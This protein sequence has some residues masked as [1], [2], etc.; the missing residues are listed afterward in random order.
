MRHDRFTGP[1]WTTRCVLKVCRSPTLVDDG[2]SGVI[3]TLA[4]ERIANE[5]VME[6]GASDV[7]A[8]L[9]RR[10][11][12]IT[13]LKDAI[14]DVERAHQT[15]VERLSQLRQS[16]TQEREKLEASKVRL[17]KQKLNSQSK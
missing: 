9:L 12:E 17:Q 1:F 8:A 7:D 3:V 13:E 16:Q 2:W 10:R 6:A 11:R 15:E 5:A 14:P 4:G